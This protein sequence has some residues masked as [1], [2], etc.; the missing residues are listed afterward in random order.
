MHHLPNSVNFQ[1][2]HLLAILRYR[3][4][5]R[6][7]SSPMHS[8]PTPVDGRLEF[9]STNTTST[10]TENATPRDLDGGSASED[11]PFE[12]VEKTVPAS[13]GSTAPDGGVTAWLV[14][15]GCFCAGFCSFGW[16]N[17]TRLV[18]LPHRSCLL[19]RTQLLVCSRNI[20]RPNSSQANIP[21]VPSHGY[22]P[23]RSSS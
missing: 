5:T 9:D 10:E 13:A 23:C 19:T 2:K 1:K 8:T 18:P 6:A 4:T 7:M 3:A 14:V 21:R 15:L 22:R 16:L 11:A 20:I 12:D 17:C